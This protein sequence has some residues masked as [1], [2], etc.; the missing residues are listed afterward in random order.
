[1]LAAIKQICQSKG[2]DYVEIDDPASIRK[3]H[4]L[5]TRNIYLVD[6]ESVL[7]WEE[8]ETAAEH[9]YYDL[10]LGDHKTANRCVCVG[11][12]KEDPYTDSFMW[13][14]GTYGLVCEEC[15]YDPNKPFRA[16]TKRAMEG[17]TLSSYH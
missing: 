11:C 9:I 13:V 3:I 5:L 14:P 10:Y 4:N 15:Y 6:D 17:T 16:R 2:W 1:M 12:R 8:P 7:G